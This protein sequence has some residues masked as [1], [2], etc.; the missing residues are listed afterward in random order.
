MKDEIMTLRN[1]IKEKDSM[2][3]KV[4]EKLKISN[5]AKH[6]MEKLV[7]RQRKH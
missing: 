1:K 7:S 5:L 3:K 2:L 4:S 6:S